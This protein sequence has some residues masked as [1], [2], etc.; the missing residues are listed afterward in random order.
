MAFFLPLLI[1]L[2]KNIHWVI[3]CVGSL[4]WLTFS[5]SQFLG[6]C[7]NLLLSWNIFLSLSIVIDIFARYSSLGCHLWSFR[8][9]KT[10]V[11]ALLAFSVSTG[12]PPVIPMGPFPLQFSLFFLCSVYLMYWTS[13]AKRTFFSG[14]VYLVLCMPLVPW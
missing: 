14:T 9:Y 7:E 3:L 10:S 5:F 12:K 6:I 4:F 2:S 13:Y 11:Q 8:I 1:F